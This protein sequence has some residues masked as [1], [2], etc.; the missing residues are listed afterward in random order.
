MCNSVQF[1]SVTQLCP[2]LCNPM[3]C[4][5]PGF[6]VHHQLQELGQTHVHRVG[7]AIQPSHSLSYPSPPAVS[8]S[9]H[10]GLFQCVCCLHQ[11]AKE[12]KLQVSSSV[13]PMNIQCWF[14]LELIGL[15][16]LLS[17]GLSKVFSITTIWK[18]QF[19]V[20]QLSLWSNSH[21]HT[22]LLEKP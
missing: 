20:L 3:D 16:A 14:P 13:P 2:I 1:G 19:F 8:L 9:Q 22:L 17:K 21:I 15:I 18:H 11:V 4:S 6:P 10:Q 5:T 7:D 12:L